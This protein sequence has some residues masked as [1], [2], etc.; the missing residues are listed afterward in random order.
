LWKDQW[1]RNPNALE[2]AIQ[3]A[4]AQWA[5]F[6]AVNYDAAAAFN[7]TFLVVLGA[8]PQLL[9][10]VQNTPEALFAMGKGPMLPL[11]HARPARQQGSSVCPGSD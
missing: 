1:I 4:E 9:M 10:Q 8:K 7:D 6:N 5:P 11:I 2:E 3:E